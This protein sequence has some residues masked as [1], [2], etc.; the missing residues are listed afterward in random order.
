MSFLNWL[1]I[2]PCLACF[3]DYTL[4][5]IFSRNENTA[6]WSTLKMQYLKTVKDSK[7]NFELAQ[8]NMKISII[9]FFRLY[10]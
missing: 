7:L 8:K 10:F 9:I 3:D 2:L 5:F 6:L 1:T 4:Q